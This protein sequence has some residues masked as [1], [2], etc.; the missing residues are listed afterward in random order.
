MAEDVT[1]EVVK[2]I[3]HEVGLIVVELT[4]DTATGPGESC[5]C[6]S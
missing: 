2:R 1:D 4:E 6:N 3:D 5:K